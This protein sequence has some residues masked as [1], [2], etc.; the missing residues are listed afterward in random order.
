[1]R[2]LRNSAIRAWYIRTATIAVSRTWAVIGQ[3]MAVCCIEASD[4]KRLDGLRARKP[5]ELDRPNRKADTGDG[6]RQ[7]DP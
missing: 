2:R 1:M 3:K 7:V 5:Q 6:Q 4:A